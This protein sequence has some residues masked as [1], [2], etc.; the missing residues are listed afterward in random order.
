MGLPPGPGWSS[1]ASARGRSCSCGVSSA[2]SSHLLLLTRLLLFALVSGP[3]RVSLFQPV[4]PL[5]KLFVSPPPPHPPARVT[6]SAWGSLSLTS[7]LPMTLFPSESPPLSAGLCPFPFPRRLSVLLPHSPLLPFPSWRP[8]M[9][10][11]PVVRP[12]NHGWELP[13][14]REAAWSGGL[15]P[16]HLTRAWPWPQ[17]RAGPPTGSRTSDASVTP[18][19]RPGR[20]PGA[21]PGH[22]QGDSPW[23][24]RDGGAGGPG[25]PV[26]M[27]GRQSGWGGMGMPDQQSHA[28]CPPPGRAMST[29]RGPSLPNPPP[30]SP[31]SG[32][33]VSALG[34]PLSLAHRPGTPGFLQPPEW[35]PLG[36]ISQSLLEQRQPPACLPGRAGRRAAG[37]RQGGG[38]GGREESW[39][40]HSKAV[41]ASL[42]QRRPVRCGAGQERG[43]LPP[44]VL[45]LPSSFPLPSPPPPPPAPG[46]L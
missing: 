12:L 29:L 2:S 3:R 40:A 43:G 44:F 38:R 23:P 33:P 4:S 14:K 25:C 21:P 1:A 36:G 18:C 45:P 22:P 8:V 30:P 31:R 20:G 9:P 32:G 6:A 24:A 7:I 26:R 42:A 5:G 11:S 39:Q 16:P 46:A 28:W 34:H 15:Q 27:P 19:P 41:S 17:S 10:L 13:Q 35:G 37:A